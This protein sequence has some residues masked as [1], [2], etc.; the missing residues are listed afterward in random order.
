MTSRLP[1]SVP[2]PRL[3]PRRLPRPG[4]LHPAACE[5]GP[6][7]SRPVMAPVCHVGP[8]M[9]IRMRSE[10]Q[11]EPDRVRVILAESSGNLPG[12][13]QREPALPI[14]WLLVSMLEVSRPSKKAKIARMSSTDHI[15]LTE[16]SY[17]FSCHHRGRLVQHFLTLSENASDDLPALFRDWQGISSN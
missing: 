4:S 2:V 16:T 14:V 12:S 5:T 13:F 7:R 6:R 1:N 8:S 9:V 10:S 17:S 15:E 3:P 11:T